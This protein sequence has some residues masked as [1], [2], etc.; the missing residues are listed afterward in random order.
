MQALPKVQRA[1]E[2]PRATEDHEATFRAVHGPSDHTSDARFG[3]ESLEE[4]ELATYKADGVCMCRIRC[5]GIH[6][7]GV[8]G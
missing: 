4:E 3:R 8:Q 6:T 1:H 5:Q 2:L 7:K